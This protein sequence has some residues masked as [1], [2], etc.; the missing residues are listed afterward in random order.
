MV[1]TKEKCKQGTHVMVATPGRLLDMIKNKF[2][3]TN[4]LKMLVVDE[5]D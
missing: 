2:L 5:A 4:D 3:S 1:E